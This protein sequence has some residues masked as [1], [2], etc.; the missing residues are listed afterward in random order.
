MNHQQERGSALSRS[1]SWF[2]HMLAGLSVFLLIPML[3]QHVR[4]HIYVYFLQTFPR[5]MSGWC[6]WGFLV[7]LALCIFFG[8]SSLFQVV[9]Q[10]I[11]RRAAR[12]AVY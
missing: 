12:R 6:A 7:I 10:L 8:I 4:P 1:V 5:E 9:V 2:A 11:L 3:D